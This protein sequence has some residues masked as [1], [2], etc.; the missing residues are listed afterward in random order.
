MAFH[1]VRM[2]ALSPLGSSHYSQRLTELDVT[3][4]PILQAPVTP[5]SIAHLL[6]KPLIASSEGN[7]I[8]LNGWVNYGAAFSLSIHFHGNSLARFMISF[9]MQHPG[10]WD[11]EPVGSTRFSLL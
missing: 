9:A 6:K 7:L 8:E 11:M 4:G 2:M 5:S 10:R 3:L 1:A